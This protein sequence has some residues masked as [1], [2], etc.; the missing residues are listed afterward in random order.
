MKPN[1]LSHLIGVSPNTVRRWT[2]EYRKY[3]TPTAAPHRGQPRVLAEHDARVMMYIA[4][5]REAGDTQD[6]ITASLDAMQDDDWHDLPQLPAEWADPD[7]TMPVALAAVRSRD[8]ASIAVLQRDLEH[9]RLA[10]QDAVG[11]AESLQAELDALRGDKTATDA[12]LHALEVE[13][14]AARGEVSTLTA[15]LST[16]AIGGDPVPLVVLV[17]VTALAAVAVVLVVLVVSRLL[18]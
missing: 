10:L 2:G 17:A 18:M 7:A 1:E 12:R 3:L 11:R 8:I 13:L 5:R 14:T 16:Y 15:K 9:T 4:A 6:A